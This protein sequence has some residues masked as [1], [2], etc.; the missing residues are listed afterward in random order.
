MLQARLT[1]HCNLYS[2]SQYCSPQ[3]P[4]GKDSWSCFMETKWSY[5]KA[6]RPAPS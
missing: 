1:E 4:K 2:L 3:P 6:K 5:K